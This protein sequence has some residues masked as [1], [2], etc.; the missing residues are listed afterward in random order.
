MTKSERSFPFT[1][2]VSSLEIFL[3][4]VSVLALSKLSSSLL[5]TSFRASLFFL[6]FSFFLW[7]YFSHGAIFCSSLSLYS[8]L[9]SVFFASSVANVISISPSLL[10]KQ[11]ESSIG[12]SFGSSLSD[13]TFSSSS[14]EDIAKYAFT[15]SFSSSSL[16]LIS[17]ALFIAAS[18]LGSVS[19]HV[20]LTLPI[21]IKW[22]N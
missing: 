19:S 7:R 1:S 12:I 4:L 21:F 17:N 13:W 20:R 22:N 11:D 8:W 18:L 9:S 3:F 2:V 5:F 14:L 15:S 10:L 6:C 16:V